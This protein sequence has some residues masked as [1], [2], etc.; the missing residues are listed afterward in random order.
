MSSSRNSIFYPGD[1][2]RY[3]AD[4]E[5]AFW[6]A[7]G[8]ESRLLPVRFFPA[9]ASAEMARLW[10]RVAPVVVSLLDK[11]GIV[12][13]AVDCVSRRQGYEHADLGNDDHTVV[14]TVRTL[15]GITLKLVDLLDSIHTESG[16]KPSHSHSLYIYIYIYII[17]GPRLIQSCLSGGLAVEVRQGRVE[18][19]SFP[20]VG[21]SFGVFQNHQAK[22]TIGGF[23]NLV[24]KSGEVSA[25]CA[26]V[27]DHVVR[28]YV[29][30]N[31]DEMSRPTAENMGKYAPSPMEHLQLLRYLPIYIYSE[32][33]YNRP[34][35]VIKLKPIY[36]TSPSHAH[37]AALTA[38]YC[39]AMVQLAAEL[40]VYKR[41]PVYTS[42]PTNAVSPEEL[43]ELEKNKSSLQ[44]AL[45]RDLNKGFIIGPVFA[46]SGY[47]FSPHRRRLDWA[48]VEM[49]QGFRSTRLN[50]VENRS[51]QYPHMQTREVLHAGRP[52]PR[53]GVYKQGSATA[54]TT[55]VINPLKSW[56][57][58]YDA[59]G[60][61]KVTFE[62]CIIPD[63]EYDCFAH[64]GDSGALVLE[65]DSAKTVGMIFGGH[66]D[67]G[68][69]YF[70]SMST[71]SS[72]IEEI[73]GLHI[74]L[75][76]ASCN[77]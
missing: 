33:Y 51:E 75:P 3:A 32:P 29:S 31:P 57:A 41:S 16:T 44:R 37:R 18:P 46:A 1:F 26:L 2:H 21:A 23:F 35:Q 45:T 5:H 8:D 25:Q 53:V 36:C 76:G 34:R 58:T 49:S 12:F 61:R 6:E 40:V 7:Q 66:L 65:R 11:H 70:T 4:G 43:S 28:P 14:V 38:N 13:D 72:D 47:R 10:T 52:R 69:A 27:S 63:K 20:P 62:W 71:L 17:L 68:P 54:T 24:K 77:G 60:K 15:P 55:G 48:L 22:G 39:R 50:K 9:Q 56:V 64:S 73:T 74:Q 42:N 59:H 67:S 19:L 30:V